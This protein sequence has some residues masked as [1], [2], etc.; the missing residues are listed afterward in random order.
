MQ[1]LYRYLGLGLFL[2]LYLP[3]LMILLPVDLLRKED[4]RGAQT[5]SITGGLLRVRM[6]LKPLEP[7]AP[8]P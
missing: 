8:N 5:A 6:P 7:V 3:P 4:Q 1:A 2:F